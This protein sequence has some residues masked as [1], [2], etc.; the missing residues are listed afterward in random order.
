MLLNEN[1]QEKFFQTFI[2]HQNPKHSNVL[3]CLCLGMF[4]SRRDFSENWLFVP[5]LEMKQRLRYPGMQALEDDLLGV[6]VQLLHEHFAFLH[7]H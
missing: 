3:N 5:H 7:H 6:A 2:Q 4:R 1:Q